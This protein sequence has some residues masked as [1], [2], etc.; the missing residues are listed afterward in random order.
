[1]GNMKNLKIVLLVLAAV[2]ALVLV[3]S[4]LNN[5]FK[6]DVA[7]AVEA[8]S[9][10]NYMILPNDLKHAEK[11]YLIIDLEESGSSR[12]ENSVKISFEKLLEDSSLEKLKEAESKILLVSTDNSVAAK[13]WV[14]LNQ[15]DF[16]N[17][18]ILSNEENPE[19]LKYEFQPDTAAKLESISE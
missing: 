11:Q 19:V 7:T 15:L 3:K 18:F 17:V 4:V 2:L 16:E 14:I 9:S 8:V 1:M 6:Q 10:K 12:F 5:G 13:A